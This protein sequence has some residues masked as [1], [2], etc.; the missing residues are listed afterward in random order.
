M[1]GAT[2]NDTAS[3]RLSSCAPNS[4]CVFVSRAMRLSSMSSTTVAPISGVVWSKR[5]FS[6]FTIDQKFANRLPVV[7]R[8]GRIEAPAGS[9]GRV[10]SGSSPGA[11]EEGWG[12][13]GFGWP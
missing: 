4:L 13:L 10:C 1:A 3:A 9:G 8:L 5:P 7:K 6:V 2:P 11:G 12:P